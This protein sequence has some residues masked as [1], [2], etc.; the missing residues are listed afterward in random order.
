MQVDKA[1][2]D[3]RPTQADVDRLASR[4][5]VAEQ[6]RDELRADVRNYQEQLGHIAVA[7]GLPPDGD[8][9]GAIERLRAQ[10]TGM[11]ATLEDFANPDHWAQDDGGQWVWYGYYPP[12][13]RPTVDL[14]GTLTRR[15]D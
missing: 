9:V 5:L 6:E 14:L 8:L 13:E 7:L 11:H 4:V 3:V 10:A 15:V 2:W 1:W 12:F